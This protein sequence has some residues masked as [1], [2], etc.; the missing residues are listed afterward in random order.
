MNFEDL[1]PELKDKAMACKS[2]EEF[3]VLL[4]A[5]GIELSNDQ[6]DDIV[7]GLFQYNCTGHF[8]GCRIDNSCRTK[9]R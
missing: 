4:E 2:R 5:E 7:G 6:L 8:E 9:K 1:A 3:M